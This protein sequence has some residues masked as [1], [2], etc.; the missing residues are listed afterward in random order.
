VGDAADAWVLKN[1]T[2]V[3]SL[4]LGDVVDAEVQGA[5]TLGAVKATRWQAGKITANTVA[6]IAT[7]GAAA[8]KTVAAVPGDFAADLALAG[9]G[10]TAKTKTLG[11]VSIKGNVPGSLWDV[12]GPVG[13]IVLAG[14]AGEAA[15]P[16]QLT[17]VTNGVAAANVASLTAYDVVNAALTVDGDI[18]AVKAAR[19]QA[20]S[21]QAKIVASIA[22]TGAAATKTAAAV[23][24]DFK[25]NVTLTDAVRKTLG[26][27]TV[28]GWLADAT[29]TSA[30]P[31]G[32]LTVGAA[33][34]ATVLAGDLTVQRTSI[35]GFSVKGIKG[36]DFAFINSNVQ[37][38]TL[39]TVAV[40]GVKT[41]NGQAS[42]GVKGH[43]VDSYVR[44]ATKLGKTDGPQTPD[45]EV[46][47][48][49]DLVA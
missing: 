25:G 42:F 6:S 43:H 9:V 11:S 34:N 22:T 31:L 37:A 45:T 13:G 47:Y 7:V 40:L 44:G 33:S 29:I 16:W 48:L 28:A 38:W 20:G 12:K 21:L 5:A 14:L 15:K 4:T 35:A 10:V 36:Q 8:T 18:G 39:G 46:D 17:G 41:D 3:A 49:L 32:A 26:T 24:G 30:G 27:M 2:T 23:S 19:W 1:A